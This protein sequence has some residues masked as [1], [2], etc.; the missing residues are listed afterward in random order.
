MVRAAGLSANAGSNSFNSSGWTGEAT[1]YV[2][3]GMTVDPGFDV[4]LDTLVISTKASSTGPGFLDVFTSLDGF[5]SPFT[6]LTQPGTNYLDEIIDLTPLG[7]VSGTFTIRLVQNGTVSAGGGVTGP[8]GTLR[9]A[10]YFDGAYTA[11]EITGTTMPVP[12]PSTI[13]LL[14][15]GGVSLFM[16]KRRRKR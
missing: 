13:V 3:F 11:P 15:L 7:T 8:T 2:E 6:M 16:L 1:D 4:A 5:A 12:E 9:V 10:D 14:G